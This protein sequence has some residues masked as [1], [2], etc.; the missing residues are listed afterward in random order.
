M[1][2]VTPQPR[3]TREF[4]PCFP[5]LPCGAPGHSPR[6]SFLIGSIQGSFHPAL[7]VAC[8]FS[9]ACR[10]STKPRGLKARVFMKRVPIHFPCRDQACAQCHQVHGSPLSFLQSPGP[11][12]RRRDPAAPAPG[13]RRSAAAGRALAPCSAPRRPPFSPQASSLMT[14]VYTSAL[15]AC[16]G[17]RG[18]P[19]GGTE[20]QR[21]RHSGHLTATIA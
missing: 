3:D 2:A 1:A 17:A 19:G 4:K 5:L 16:R 18:G 7:Q 6:G 11:E 15:S 12:P 9:A 21:R 8:L 20:A 10:L 14:S 13:G